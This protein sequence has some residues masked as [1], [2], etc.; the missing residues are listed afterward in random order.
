MPWRL[1]PKPVAT[2]DAAELFLPI[3]SQHQLQTK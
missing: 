1:M 2:S 3:A